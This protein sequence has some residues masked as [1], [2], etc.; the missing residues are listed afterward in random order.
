MLAGPEE[1]ARQQRGASSK[2]E[3]RSGAGVGKLSGL[4]GLGAP[5]R[6]P[7]FTHSGLRG[8][9]AGCR[10]RGGFSLQGGPGRGTEVF[11]PS[12]PGCRRAWADVSF[13]SLRVGGELGGYGL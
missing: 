6:T 9:G 4:L 3:S 8:G 12:F 7:P 11:L 5:A 13:S 1:G 2:A 10:P